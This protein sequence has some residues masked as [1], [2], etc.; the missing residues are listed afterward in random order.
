MYVQRIWKTEKRAADAKDRLSIGALE[1]PGPGV[2]VKH[3]KKKGRQVK[4]RQTQKKV[5]DQK[6]WYCERRHFSKDPVC[7]LARENPSEWVRRT[8]VDRRRSLVA[9]DASNIFGGTKITFEG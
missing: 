8:R 9:Q 6:C 5:R 1:L 3:S 7:P 4:A 2:G